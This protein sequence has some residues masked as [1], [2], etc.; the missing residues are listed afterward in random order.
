MSRP[1]SQIV[2]QLN[3]LH[4]LKFDFSTAGVRK[5]EDTLNIL[6]DLSFTQPAHYKKYYTEL[7]FVLAYPANRSIH[8][9]ASSEFR[10]LKFSLDENKKMALQLSNAGLPGV[11]VTGSFSHHLVK[12]LFTHD[13]G[14]VNLHSI[15]GEPG[16]IMQ[17]LNHFLS[18]IEKEMLSE[19]TLSWKKWLTLFGGKS[20]KEQLDF[21]LRQTDQSYHS[22]EQRE[23]VFASL[24][25]FVTLRPGYDLTRF[26]LTPSLQ[27]SAYYY[28]DGPMRS[29]KGDLFKSTEKPFH[30]VALSPAEKKTLVNIARA[31]LYPLCKETDPFTFAAINETE[32]FTGPHGTGIA[33]YYMLP[34]KKLA[35]ESYCGYLLFR[36]NIPVAYGG[37][38]LLGYQ[39]RFGLNIL[40]AF[41]GG[42]SAF[43]AQ[44]LVQLY[45]THFHVQ[46][47]IIEP[48]QLG[49]GNT[50]GIRSAAFWFYY[51]MGFRPVQKELAR[52]ATDEFRKLR[53]GRSVRTG[54]AELK[55]LS[56]SVMF[57][58]NKEVKLTGINTLS[59]AVTAYIKKHFQN[60]R[61][62]AEKMTCRRGD[63][64][65]PALINAMCDEPMRL[66]KKEMDAIN[67][68]FRLKRR[69]ER[70]YIS[71][72]QKHPAF[73]RN[74][75]SLAGKIN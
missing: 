66:D 53:S 34:E 48:F 22:I 68:L 25:L 9:K 69:N 63:V 55:K 73:I 10:R 44:S 41:R 71:G 61:K 32:Y 26:A 21:L 60:D 19:E 15:D 8:D 36:N 59:H 30:P 33:L 13:P 2:Q 50:D 42:E 52:L 35:L 56:H 74:L 28:P 47:F 24:K 3:A 37:G 40:P 11:P 67:G 5:L 7:L 57:A 4:A 39:C 1:V 12:D 65:E 6:A 18:G 70:G 72:L 51:R 27:Q 45:A 29:F 38:W 31:T 16:A 14:S 20:K 49:K 64:F 46:A 17:L 58:G 54:I 23:S 75:A 43:I 62:R